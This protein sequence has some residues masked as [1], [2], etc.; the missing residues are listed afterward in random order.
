MIV[1]NWL[2]SRAITIA[3]VLAAVVVV[4][5]AG[6]TVYIAHRIDAGALEPNRNPQARPFEVVSLVGDELT[7]RGDHR[8]LR[9]NGIWGLE[10]DGGYGQVGAIV[11]IDSAEGIVVRDYTPINGAP[12]AGTRVRLDNFAFPNTPSSRGLTFEEVTYPAP[13]G[14]TPA[15]RLPGTE[16]TWAVFVHGRGSNRG[17]AVRVLPVTSALSMPALVIE[18]RNDADAPGGQSGKYAYGRTEWEDLEAAV[19]Y[20]LDAGAS[21]IV[22][23]GYS[24]GGAIVM[25]FMQRSALAARVSGLI[26]DAPMLDFSPTADLGLREGGVPGW[27]TGPPKWFAQLRYDIDWDATDYLRDLD[28][29]QAPV[30]LFHTT[31]DH[32]VPVAT[33]DELAAERDDLV[34]YLRTDGDGHVSSWNLHPAE[35]EAAVRAFLTG[36][37]A[38][39]RPPR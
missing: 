25:S 11:R 16:S 24:M 8:D 7:L 5:F 30:L 3:L 21:D 9:R 4:A 22:L 37:I 1:A 31:G 10:W 2:R 26:L 23:A 20:A 35:Y 18:Y 38:D 27:F 12:A 13:G 29:L 32:I 34:T 36:L 33:S 15:W 6:A 39:S 28:E 17:E 19:Q 14:P